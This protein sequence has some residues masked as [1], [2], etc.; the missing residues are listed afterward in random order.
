[1]ARRTRER[2]NEKATMTATAVLTKRQ[3]IWDL[4]WA[5]IYVS[6]VKNVLVWVRTQQ[7]TVDRQWWEAI[8][9]SSI[10]EEG[11]GARHTDSHLFITF[12]RFIF[13]SLIVEQSTEWTKQDADETENETERSRL[14]YEIIMCRFKSLVGCNYRHFQCRISHLL[15]RKYL[16]KCLRDIFPSSCFSICDSYSLDRLILVSTSRSRASNKRK[17][18]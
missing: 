4:T 15:T 9:E 14:R 10:N 6:I 3:L 18:K 11:P 2:E 17:I 5:Q 8:V 12:S 7:P 13:Y 16:I 1:M